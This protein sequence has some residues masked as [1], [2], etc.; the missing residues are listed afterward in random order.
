[1]QHLISGFTDYLQYEKRY[2]IHTVQAYQNDLEQFFLFIR[3]QFEHTDIKTISHIHIRSWLA[4]LK[5]METGSISINR[6]I[7]TLKSFYRFLLKKEFVVENPMG[8]IISPKNSKRLPVFVNENNM[9]NL[10]EQPLFSDDF[11]GKTDKLILELLYQTGMRRAELLGLQLVN[12]DASN[13][14]VKVLGKGNKERLIPIQTELCNLLQEYIL[15]RSTVESLTHS[16]LLTFE[17][18]KPLYEKYIYLTVKKYLSLITTIDKKSPH[19]LRHTFA[20]HILN[21]GADLNAVKELLGHA[22]LS[23]TQVYTHNTIEKLKEV[24]K[25]AHPKA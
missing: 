3:S 22:N 18:G 16:N 5:E 19:V 4:Q 14:T 17:N 8:K 2:S 1:M 15:V 11:K 13:K 6:K 9:A 12:V 20:T 24:H 7:S 23:A 10:M 21:K 25:K